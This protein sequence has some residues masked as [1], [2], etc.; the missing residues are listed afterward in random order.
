VPLC[1]ATGKVYGIE[2]WFLPTLAEL[3]G[4]A[5]AVALL[6]CLRAE[7]DTAK[8]RKTVNQVLTI[9]SQLLEVWLQSQ[10]MAHRPSPRRAKGQ[11]QPSEAPQKH[12]A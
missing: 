2:E 4:E 12:Q 8:V 6:R 3:L 7:T 10:R 9:G 5:R 1:T 11:P